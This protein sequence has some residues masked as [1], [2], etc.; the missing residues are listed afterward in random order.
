MEQY[1]FEFRTAY[2]MSI[3][4]IRHIAFRILCMKINSSE[5]VDDIKFSPVYSYSKI[6]VI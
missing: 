5:A 3:I 6:F 4:E 1:A 2:K